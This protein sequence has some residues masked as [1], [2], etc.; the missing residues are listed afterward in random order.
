MIFIGLFFYLRPERIK[1][2]FFVLRRLYYAPVRTA[3]LVS[4]FAVLCFL[5][6]MIIRSGNFFV[7]PVS[8]IEIS[9]RSVLEDLFLVRPRT[10]EFLIGYPFLLIAFMYVDAKISRMWI[11]FFNILGSIAL[12]SVVNSFCHLHTPLSVSIYRSVLGVVLGVLVTSF[13]ILTYQ[14]ILKL[15]YK[16]RA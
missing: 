1:S 14:L 11:W 8:F 5:I 12:I 16:K 15:F 3:G 4:V 13:Y 6:L 10:K 2:T 9:F 7:L